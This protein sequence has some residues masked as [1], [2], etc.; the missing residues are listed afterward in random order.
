MN[1][2][3]IDTVTGAMEQGGI[4]MS[5]R[6]VIALVSME[7]KECKTRKTSGQHVKLNLNL[8]SA[9]LTSVTNCSRDRTLTLSKLHLLL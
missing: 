2:N 5:C 4:Y 7:T 3:L 1:L 8:E 6:P 9:P